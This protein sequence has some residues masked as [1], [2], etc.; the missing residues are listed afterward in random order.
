MA[1]MVVVVFDTENQAFEGK[2]G[3]EKLDL[4]GGITNYADAV[5]AKNADGS[6]AVEQVRHEAPIATIGGTAL[7][8]LIGLLGGPMAVGIGAGG[9]FLAGIIADVYN[10]GIGADFVDEVLKELTPGK[11][12]L[13]ADIEELSTE[14]LDRC[15]ESIGGKV[16]RRSKSE[17]R[18]ALHEEYVAA[19]KADLTQLRADLATAKAD[20]RAILTLRINR[21]E[22]GIQAQLK[23]AKKS[24]EAAEQEAFDR[25]EAL[26]NKTKELRAR[27]AGT[28]VGGARILS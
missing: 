12:A 15:M 8:S 16:F 17:V 28:H 19:M 21:L 3:L 10:A 13:V 27:A 5:I 25:A 9:G 14:P 22:A 1:K 23:R 7:G 26:K 24:R 4:A 18:H 20:R 11:Y 2:T 6:T